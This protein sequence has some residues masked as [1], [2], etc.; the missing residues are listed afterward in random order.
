[1]RQLVLVTM[2]SMILSARITSVSEHS[3]NRNPR[4]LVL[5]IIEMIENVEH[6]VFYGNMNP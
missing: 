4:L 5:G 6:L 2:T 1:M 3:M